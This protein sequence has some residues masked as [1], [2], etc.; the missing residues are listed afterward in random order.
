MLHVPLNLLTTIDWQITTVDR[1]GSYPTRPSLV[2]D[3][4][5]APAIAYY[6]GETDELRFAVQNSGGSWSVGTVDSGLNGEPFASLAYRLGQPAISYSYTTYPGTGPRWTQIRYAMLR[7]NPPWEIDVVEQGFTT[8]S[9]IPSSLAFD[10]SH[11]A[12]ISYLYSNYVAYSRSQ[13][14]SVWIRQFAD[15]GINWS[16]SL[17]FHEGTPAIASGDFY[18]NLKYAAFDGS[19]WVRNTIA[20]GL[21]T[22]RWVKLAFSPSGEP[23]MVYEF[24]SGGDTSIGFAALSQGN[25]TRQTIFGNLGGTASLAFTPSGEPAISFDERFLFGLKYAVL[26]NGSWVYYTVEETGGPF[27]Y[28][29]LAFNPSGEPAISYYDQ[30][31]GTIKYAVGTVSQGLMQSPGSSLA[32]LLQ[33]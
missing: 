28:P 1:V 3:P 13:T 12:C 24:G 8:R 15:Q 11:R 19:H 18:G 10:P 31:N 23:A 6:G 7:E 32:G 4:A 33:G 21:S 2:F 27:L 29:C 14:P 16:S 17:A 22:V 26:R 5:G 25:W 9:P 30:A 20:Q